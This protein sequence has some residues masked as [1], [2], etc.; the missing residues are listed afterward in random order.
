LNRS[1]RQSFF[2]PA[3]RLLTNED[4]HL[5][6]QRHLHIAE[7]DERLIEQW[8]RN[9]R[10]NVQ[11]EEEF[12]AT[13]MEERGAERHARWVFIEAKVEE[14]CSQTLDDDDPRRG[15]LWTKMTSGDEDVE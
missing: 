7:R 10:D 3:S 14:P 9:F 13:K 2:A 15:D 4:R 8:R 5:R 1:R 11:A 6:R 12:W